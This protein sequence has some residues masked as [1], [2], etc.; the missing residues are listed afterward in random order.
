MPKVDIIQTSF[1]G[2]EFGPSLYG[3]SDIA[4]YANACAIVENFIPRSYGPA[5]S[6]PG[7]RYV[8]TVSDSTLR[9]R[10]IPFIF[11]KADSYIIEMGDM[12]MRFF[13]N[14]GQ[15][16]TKTGT[17]DLSA[18]SANL[19]AHWKCNDNTNSTTVLDATASHNG[20]ASTLTQSLS[21][22][23]IVTNGFNLNGRYHISVADHADFTRTASSQPMTIA[24][25]FYYDKNGADQC[26]FSKSG[27]YEL[28]INSSDE[29]SFITQSGT[30]DVKLL[31]HCDGADASTTFTDS[32][33][34][35][36]TVTANG[37]AQIDTADYVFGTG[38][39]LFDG[40]GDYLSIPDSADWNFGTGDFTIDCRVKFN[41]LSDGDCIVAQFQDGSHYWQLIYDS[42]NL[43]FQ[44]ENG[45]GF[46][47]NIANAWTPS[48]GVWY[49][50]ALVS[51][52][53]NFMMFI[54]GMQIGSTSL[55]ASG[56]AD[57]AGSLYI[58]YNGTIA[59]SALD[60]WIDEF[61]IIK[62][63]AVWTSNF[64]PSDTP[65]QSAVTNSWKVNDNIPKGW[66][67][68]A[69]VFKGTGASSSDF[70]IYI[71]GVL[72]NLT[73][74]S[75]PSFVKMSD[76]SSSFRIGTT[77][78]AGA[79]NWKSKIDDIAFIHQELTAANILSLYSTSAYQITTVFTESEIFDVQ[80]SQL[81][82]VVYLSHPNHPPQKLIRTSSNEWSIA[83]F[84]FKGGPFLDDNKD[85]TITITPSATT[86]TINI[87]VSPTTTS[88]FTLST[89]T[90]GHVNS[91]WKIG[92]LAQTNA[93][94]GLQEEGYVQITNVVNSYTATATVI[95]N[96]K[97]T[98]A[99]STWA[100][101]AW[102][103]V[104]GY[105]ARITLH[106]RR[107]WFARTDYEPQKIW[108][109]KTFVF[110]DYS[111]DT[112]ADDDGLNLALASNES[113][114]IQWLASGKSLI[115]GTFGGAFVINSKSTD[116]ITPN[117]A[118]ASEEVGYGP[119]SIMPKR[120]GNFIYYLERFAKKIRE[121]F[122]FWDLDTYK[123]IDRTILSPHILGDGVVD[124]D[125]AKNPETIIYCVLTSG[126]LATLTRE[127]DQEMTAWARQTTN[128]TYSSIAIIP[129][130]TAEYDEA[131]VIVE[132][133][134]GG[135]Q[136]RYIEY[137]ETI[138]IPNRQDQCLYLHCALT[139]DAYVSTSTSNCTISLS[140][141]SGSVTVTS[142]TAYFAGSQIGKR[143]RAIDASG[144][145]L[146]E[147]QITGTNSTTSITLSITTTFNS[148]AYIAG[149]WG[150]S[151]STI[152][153][154]GHLETKTVGIL[155]DG[156]TESLTRTV[157][158]GS[159]TLGS[160]YFVI[161]AGLSYNQ[162][163]YTLPKEAGSQRGTSQGKVQ[164]FN[165]VA[166]KVNRST[167][168][169]YYGPDAS[170]LD[171]VSVAITPSVSTLYTGVLAPLGF[172]GG[173]ARGA[174]V[175]IKNSNPLPIELLNVIGTL[176]TYD[177]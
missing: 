124:M 26:L 53:N 120:I 3:R 60:G 132:R 117:N 102:S 78:S 6:T 113:N 103:A 177:K 76:T 2:G 173:Y 30:G 66:N 57:F 80:F 116:P 143:L 146:G 122:Y 34:S 38:S 89:G 35:S 106:E 159:I 141:T 7:T 152:S 84:A 23:A 36:N 142:S 25:W 83:N 31:L 125:A 161:N 21:T 1:A 17:E 28:S 128:G 160:N 15:V 37:N 46:T 92:G 158:S 107:L 129:S 52:S 74:T 156:N 82:D 29:M 162:L 40:S 114:E 131:W 65:Y 157:A 136:K 49:H 41:S 54:N 147:G 175:Y 155:A 51:S 24:G 9:T 67:F 101:G 88:L 47:H 13:T 98:T 72:K 73:F 18:F 144:T 42:G 165:E 96:L 168:N 27:E 109:S 71:D 137:F 45:S 127:V 56:I 119:A 59:G 99:T 151:V 105:P 63:T 87:T 172:R 174:Q 39:G 133:W 150:I 50:I 140:G 163:I 93:T 108:G 130:Q 32:S 97:A 48:T 91:Y 81:N 100:E 148:L 16:V 121:M 14:R 95:K 176:E 33:P 58:A 22:T 70:K 4:Q 69:V 104:R 166:F 153:G 94:T 123:A 5:I 167:Q 8:A 85:T 19:K 169:F 171:L 62:G 86:G 135:N 20:T 12:Y 44:S 138:E 64:A 110:D 68:V 61:R 118:N 75:D 149:R 115:A 77:S 10:I 43:K 11:N 126:T 139:Y 90:L 79:K 111:L 170:N 112:Q 164:R 55:N 154:L 134:V 145:T